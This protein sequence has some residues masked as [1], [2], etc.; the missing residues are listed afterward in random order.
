MK[1]IKILLFILLAP[2]YLVSVVLI[3]PTF[4]W[5]DSLKD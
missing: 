2:V 5:W 4:E 1:I 3:W